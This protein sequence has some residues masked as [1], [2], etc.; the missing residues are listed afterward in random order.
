MMSRMPEDYA[1]TTERL[2]ADE[3][4][5]A[6]RTHAAPDLPAIVAAML[7]E[8]VTRWLP[9]HWQGPYT[10]A[11]AEAWIAEQDAEGTVL[12][13]ENQEAGEP[14]GL[15]LLFEEP[16]AGGVDVRLGYLLAE[17]A[18]GQ[19]YGGELLGGFVAWCKGRSDVR[20]IIGGVAPENAASIRLLERH[21]FV[22]EPEPAPG[23]DLTYRLVIRA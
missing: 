9:P 10:R 4:H 22:C 17:S 14:L 2:R 11:R 7:T 13:V 3:W 19:G 16:E 6:G 20:S 15:V 18:W 12:L 1:F 23:E 8:P 5:G 21:G